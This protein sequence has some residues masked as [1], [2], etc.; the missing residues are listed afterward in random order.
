L[1]RVLKFAAFR[2]DIAFEDLEIE[3]RVVYRGPAQEYEDYEEE[4]FQTFL[5]KHGIGSN[6]KIA[7]A[8]LFFDKY[9]VK[10][11]TSE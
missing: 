9:V 8:N 5:K 2:D 11:E 3:G 6:D 10:L 1:R 4:V 7:I